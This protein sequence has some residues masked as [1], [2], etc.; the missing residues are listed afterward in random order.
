MNSARLSAPTEA[1]GDHHL[2][3]GAGVPGAALAQRRKTQ[4]AGVPQ[5]D[6]P[7]GDAD[8]VTC[9][10]VGWQLWVGP[11]DLG[12]CRRPVDLDGIGV[13]TG[14]QQPRSLVEADPHLLRHVIAGRAGPDGA[15]MG[16]GIGAVRR[17][18]HSSTDYWRTRRRRVAVG[19]RRSSPEVSV[20]APTTTGPAVE[21]IGGQQLPDRHRGLLAG[22][23]IGVVI[24]ATE[25]DGNCR[26]CS[27]LLGCLLR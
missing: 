21:P 22:V 17:G 9:G 11:A 14:G 2:Q 10:G 25:S 4:L 5:E 18:A 7:T 1:S 20:A 26:R 8:Q 3:L 13:D 16:L 12:Q 27:R 24:R 23:A 15:G 6:H 19:L